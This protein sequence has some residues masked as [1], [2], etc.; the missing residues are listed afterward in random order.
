M[1]RSYAVSARPTPVGRANAKASKPATE[2]GEDDDGLAALRSVRNPAASL[3][4]PLPNA[5][6]RTL[7]GQ[8]HGAPAEVLAPI[9]ESFFRD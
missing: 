3:A 2:D 9:L 4:A 8:G 5:T 6:H 1:R 7:A